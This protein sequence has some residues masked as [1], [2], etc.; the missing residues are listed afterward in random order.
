MLSEWKTSCARRLATVKGAV[1][2]RDGHKAL[3]RGEGQEPWL[4]R[5]ADDHLAGRAP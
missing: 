2:I 1:E 4:E 3:V 5:T